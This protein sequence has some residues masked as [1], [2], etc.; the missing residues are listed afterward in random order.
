MLFCQ[1]FQG[2]AEFFKGNMPKSRTDFFRL[3]THGFET[4]IV[5]F[6]RCQKHQ[7]IS[8]PPFD[9]TFA[10]ADELADIDASSHFSF[11]NNMNRLL[12]YAAIWN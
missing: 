2:I 1:T 7:I 11:D 10:M 4:L 3:A 9:T 8:R 12:E 6:I 5:R